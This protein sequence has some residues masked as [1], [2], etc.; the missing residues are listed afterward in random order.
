[1]GSKVVSWFVGGL[2]YQIEHHLFP[3]VSHVHYPEISK[4]VMAK[5]KELG[6][7]RMYAVDYRNKSE[8]IDPNLFRRF[9]ISN[10]T[11]T[12]SILIQINLA[13]NNYGI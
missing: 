6:Y 4:I 8:K 5:C 2:N 13:F 3:K 10:T 1:M 12:E 9:S 7:E 11:T